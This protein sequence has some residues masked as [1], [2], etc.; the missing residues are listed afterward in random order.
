MQTLVES[1]DR[2]DIIKCGILSKFVF[3]V[4]ACVFARK[5]EK[6]RTGLSIFMA[7]KGAGSRI[8]LSGLEIKSNVD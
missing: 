6:E 7:S 3:C 4:R 2:P 5:G 8:F 1:Q